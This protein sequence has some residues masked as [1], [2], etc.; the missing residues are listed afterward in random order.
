MTFSGVPPFSTEWLQVQISNDKKYLGSECM[1][2]QVYL[3][4]KKI[5]IVHCSFL[6]E[7]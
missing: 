5:P 1:K 4:N 7:N 2:F 3:S 6:R